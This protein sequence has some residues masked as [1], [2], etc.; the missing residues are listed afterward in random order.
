MGNLH[1]E[2]IPKIDDC[3]KKQKNNN[4]NEKNSDFH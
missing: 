3:E 2:A 1:E 4:G